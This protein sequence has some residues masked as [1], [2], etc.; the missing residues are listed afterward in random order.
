MPGVIAV[1]CYGLYGNSSSYFELG[2]SHR[3]LEAAAVQSTVTF[4]LNGLVFF[5]AGASAVNFLTRS[6][7]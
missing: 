1:V 6:V 7:L 4:A 5:F 2:S 3:T